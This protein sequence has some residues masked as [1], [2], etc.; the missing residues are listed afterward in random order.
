MIFF[1]GGGPRASQPSDVTA[2]GNTA[3]VL[4][5][6]LLSR[7][8]HAAWFSEPDKRGIEPYWDVG[9]FASSFYKLP[10]LST[11]VRPVPRWEFYNCY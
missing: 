7:H 6:A 4:C 11:M 5:D 3:N 8:F 1:L 9:G 10:N 2:A